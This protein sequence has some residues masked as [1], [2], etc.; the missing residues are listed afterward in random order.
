MN[1]SKWP[2]SNVT[3]GHFPKTRSDVVLLGL[4]DMPADTPTVNRYDQDG[5]KL[6]DPRGPALLMVM[7][8][9]WA[10]YHGPRKVAETVG[11]L[12]EGKSRGGFSQSDLTPL[13]SLLDENDVVTVRLD[14]WPRF[15]NIVKDG[16][17]ELFGPDRGH[18]PGEKVQ[19]SRYRL[20]LDE[21]GQL[22][23]DGVAAPEPTDPGPTAEE[24]AAIDASDRQMAAER[25]AHERGEREIKERAAREN[26]E[27]DERIERERREQEEAGR[28]ADEST[29]AERRRHAEEQRREKE[30]A[31]K[32]RERLGIKP[33]GEVY[34]TLSASEDGA[35]L[36]FANAWSAMFAPDDT[37]G[38]KALLRKERPAHTEAVD[39]V[40]RLLGWSL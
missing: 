6:P 15:A 29:A 13:W 20:S 23:I 27:N 3:L 8:Q 24:Q 1:L 12:H 2:V 33:A 14:V 38:F 7:F 36:A 28:R 5:Q 31:A 18:W 40:C 26:R 19:S 16:E 30:R 25:E 34:E 10:I 37:D 11:G 21:N 17:A 4:C 32:E 9:L 39:E 35:V 22:L